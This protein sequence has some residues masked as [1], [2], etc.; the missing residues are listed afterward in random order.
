VLRA[1]IFE[2]TNCT[3]SVGLGP[4]LLLSRLATRKAKPDGIFFLQ[5]EEAKDYMKS[6]AVQDLPGT[7]T[8][9]SKY[10]INIIIYIWSLQTEKKCLRL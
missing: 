4:S 9:K 10:P 3:A 7:G 1:E 2:A 8:L 6:V 5:K